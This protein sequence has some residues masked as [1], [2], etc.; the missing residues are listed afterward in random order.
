[1]NDKLN[2]FSSFDE[3]IENL[4]LCALIHK[5]PSFSAEQEVRISP[6]L[7]NEEDEHIEYK[8]MNLIKRVHIARIDELCESTKVEF[9]ELI[10]K[11][12]IGPKSARNIEDLK[13]YLKTIG[14][15]ELKDKV[16][17]SECPLR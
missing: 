6:L 14:L 15:P 3:L 17:K 7:I 8:V 16:E 10:E 4:R 5:H 2:E 1:M 11:I 13:W 12:V 9:P